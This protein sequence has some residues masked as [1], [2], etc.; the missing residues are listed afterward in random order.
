VEEDDEEEV[1]DKVVDFPD[2]N[3]EAAIRDKINKPTGDIYASDLETVTTLNTIGSK[4]IIYLT[5]LE[6]C[7]NITQLNAYNNQISDLSPLAGL[8]KLQSLILDYNQIEDMSALSELANLERLN[9]NNNMV[10]SIPDLQDLKQLRD[11]YLENNQLDDIDGVAGLTALEQLWIAGNQIQE[12]SALRGLTNLTTL[13]AYENK[14][15]T[16]FSLGVLETLE[17]VDLSSNTIEDIESLEGLPNLER[18]Y[19]DE[20]KI[21]DITPLVANM[22]IGE[23]DQLQL[24]N[25]YLSRNCNPD[26]GD[27]TDCDNIMVLEA[28]GVDVSWD[29]QKSPPNE[30]ASDL[31]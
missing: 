26:G 22:G 14:I 9:L 24:K 13:L 23:G 21:S 16:I 2:P 5:G 4:K 15:D 12:I 29:P 10:E 6:F 18:L 1:A 25:N 20:N 19:L 30:K 31:F 7:I 3:L 8:T 28:R 11:L 27:T 17:Y